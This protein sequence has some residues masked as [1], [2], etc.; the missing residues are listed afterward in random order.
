MTGYIKHDP[1]DLTL[2]RIDTAEKCLDHLGM[3]LLDVAS[4]E[5]VRREKMTQVGDYARSVMKF[6]RGLRETFTLRQEVVAAKRTEEK[7]RNRLASRKTDVSQ[8]HAEPKEKKYDHLNPSDSGGSTLEDDLSRLKR[9]LNDFKN[10]M[11]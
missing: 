1:F 5:A 9:G 7:R 3:Q 8:N 11:E 10:Q 6:I 2:A 4:I